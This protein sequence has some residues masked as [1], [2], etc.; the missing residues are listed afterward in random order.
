[1]KFRFLTVF[2]ALTVLGMA[3]HAGAQG[4]TTTTIAGTVVDVGGGVVPGASVTVSRADTGF[5]QTAETNEQGAFSFAGINPGTY[6]VKVTLQ[7]FKT[8][9]TNDVVVTSGAPANVSVKLEVG[10]LEETVT[11]SSRSEII[12]AQAPTVSSTINAA[13]ILQLPLTTRSAMD[14]VTFLPGV[15]TAGG[16]RSSQ[17]SG[18]PRGLI[19]ITLDG[20]NI[21]DNTLRTTDGFFAIV[22]PRL[23]AIEE[24]TV[25]TAAQGAD[26][27][28]QGAVQIKFVTRSGSNQ[29]TGSG[30]EYFRSDKLNANT[31]FNNRNGVP[32]AKLKQNQFGVRM[33]GPVIIPG[34]YDGR[35][36]MFFFTNQEEQRQPSDVTRTRNLMKPHAQAG[37]FTYGGTTVNLLAIAA[38]NGLTST[39]DPI[40]GKLLADIRQSTTTTGSVTDRDGLNIDQFSYNVPVQ[41]M[42]RYPTVRI[43]YNLTDKHRF[44]SSF[45]YNHFTDFPDTLNGFDAQWPGFPTE[46]GQSSK[47]YSWSNAMRSTVSQNVV[48]EA[49]VGYSAAP[50][51]FFAE[52]AAP[53]WSGSLAN[54]GGFQLSFPNIG[55]GLTN[56]STGPA[57][58][59]RNASSLLIEDTVTWLRGSH[60]LTMGG[61]FTQFDL[62]AHNQALVPILNFG[63]VAG[64]PALAVIG[65]ANLP[66]ANAT[67]I[68]NAQ[69]L[70]SFLTGRVQTING[71][72][73]LD[74]ATGKYVYMGKGTQ[75]ARMREAGFFFQDAWRVKPNL[76][77]NAGLRYE[78][79]LPF[80]PL[81]SS[82]STAT[83]ADLC[84]IS[85]VGSNG[86]CNL[87]QPGVTPG[88]TPPQFT[89]FGKGSNA[90]NTDWDNFAPS[91]GFAWSIAR[92]DGFLGKLLS[93]DFV[94]RGGW[95][96]AFNREG[97]NAFSGQYNA[98]PGVVIQNGDRNVGAGNLN[99]DG[100]GLPVLFRDASRL[101]PAPFPE[102]PIFP[103]TDVVTEDVNIFDPDLKVPYAD[104]WTVGVQ[105]SVGR[106]MAVEARYVGTRSR[107]NWQ[108]FNHNEINVFENNFTQEF[109][110]AQAN[111]QANVA[112]GLA[113][114][115]FRYRGPGTGTV[116][117]PIMYAFLVGP[118]NANDPAG[119]AASADFATNTT[120][121]NPLVRWNPNP[122]NFANG[123]INNATFR[124]RGT[125]A[126]IARNFFIANPDALL[127]AD[128]TVNAGRSRYHSLQLE[129]RRRLAQGLQFQSN[130]AFGK[131]YVFDPNN[132]G[133]PFTFRLPNLMRRDTGDPG[134]ITHVF[135]ANIVYDLPF[136][137]GRRFGSNANGLVHRIIGEW[138]FGINA[139]VQSGRLVDLGNVRLVGMSA[140]DVQ[141]F[142]KLRFDDAGRKVWNMPQDVIDQT[143]LA[144]STS[145]TTASGYSGAAPSGRY[146]AP[147]NGPDC[148]EVAG[149]YGQCGT[150]SLVVT[151]PLF[152][153][154]DLSL[155]KRVEIVGR[156]NAE[157]R[158]EALNVFNHANFVPV[159]G[160]GNTLSNYEVT[161]VTGTNTSR[162]VQLVVRFNW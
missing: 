162:V 139:R 159:G 4:G 78:V 101:G 12:Q 158:V 152:Q 59:S 9:V 91:I 81:N 33:G 148:I 105:R 145:P 40:I 42:R 135:K 41:S 72:A 80:T 17:V 27:A 146:F 106:N 123:L 155:S 10:G 51:V 151:G 114:Q 154:H 14:F 61:S 77:L 161:G 118:G 127:G 56:A 26:T 121:L 93:D 116:P 23:D 20:V 18:L 32:V 120:F 34:L 88:K 35:G 136:G 100:L 65:A 149:G 96:R 46:A 22:A 44:S 86:R 89:Q 43:D 66:G 147:A 160:L 140:K 3:A 6:I 53:Q 68:A 95:T 119:Y 132:A 113:N 92:R 57:P 70:Y 45:N 5:S 133:G 15:T 117:L 82:Y 13:Q 107:D 110:N 125:A 85:G 39:I 98:N 47:R 74:E 141:G 143:I 108:V 124:N 62:W 153:Q 104:S 94:L 54:Q 109:R 31:W 157:F 49:R 103:I 67:Q 58:Q 156:T 29:F 134:D 75:R 48:N 126:G 8:F 99:N 137:R 37:N 87:F 122:Q 64:D 112:A 55:Q 83:M 30:Y 1:M 38:A 11:V 19:N 102:T 115:G 60:N 144:F 28:G 128:L 138:S 131:M 7:G 111:L 24:V 16:N 73:R 76:T 79:Q 71:D 63:I 130:Y 21:Q 84:G 69:A 52:A 25:T 129:L 50:V 97:M 150:G 90:T 142:Y 2:L 36:K